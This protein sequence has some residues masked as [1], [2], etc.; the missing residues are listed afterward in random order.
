MTLVDLHRHLKDLV[1]DAE[2]AGDLERA[3][4]LRDLYARISEIL[5]EQSLP[6]EANDR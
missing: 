4:R 6:V 3:F 5:L 2:C 1:I